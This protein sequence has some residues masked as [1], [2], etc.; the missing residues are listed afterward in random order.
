MGLWLW[1]VLM[2]SPK[3][4]LC[5][6]AAHAGVISVASFPGLFLV[7]SGMG[8]GSG[9]LAGGVMCLSEAVFLLAMFSDE[10]GFVPSGCRSRRR[11]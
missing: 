6:A 8:S 10:L 1:M 4:F 7:F 2:E 11:K 9:K 5:H 3:E